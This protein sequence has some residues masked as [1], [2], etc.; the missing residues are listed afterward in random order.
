M[1]GPQA[2]AA[3][4][5]VR[6][7]I[8]APCF[9]EAA[10][11]VE[12]HRR[13]TA[14]AVLAAGLSY[15]IVLVND[16]SRDATWDVMMDLAADDPRL[17]AVNLSR[18]YG[19]QIALTAGLQAC[20]GDRVLIIDADLQDPPELLPHMMA[21]MD[22]GAEVVYGQ[23]RARE[24]ETRF[25]TWTAALFYRLLRRLVDIDMPLDT[26]DFR[27]VTRRACDVLNSMPEQFR[28]VRGMM[29][30]MGFVQVPIVYDRDPRFAGATGYSL[31]KM[32]RFAL[33]AITGFSTVPLRLA[34]YMGLG[35][36]ALSLAMIAYTIL[37]WA[38]GAAVAG[39]TSLTAIVLIIGSTQLLVLGMFGEYLGRLYMEAKRRPLYVVESVVPPR[40]G[41]AAEHGNEPAARSIAS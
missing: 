8:V 11:L 34:S 41:A 35:M 26:G 36:A 13:V 20:R 10:G 24:G 5:P 17:V 37:G 16:G 28:F 27:L 7:S 19:H 23:R 21:M 31:A 6:L 3:R 14:A 1:T 4:A 39:W 40:D 9:N 22:D 29:S 30:W 18:N 33:D 12:F 2:E 15:E 25:K 32:V 38:S